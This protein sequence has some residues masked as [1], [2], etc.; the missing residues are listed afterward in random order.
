MKNN[1]KILSLNRKASYL[2]AIKDKFEAGIV[3]TGEEVKSIRKGKMNIDAAFITEQQ[4]ELYLV[5]SNIAKY[6]KSNYTDHE[7]VRHRKLLLHKK[8]INKII[9]SIKMPKYS[10]IVLKIYT[11]LRNKIKL[12]IAIACGKTE[13]DKRATIKEREWQRE[14]GKLLKINKNHIN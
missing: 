3:L 7:E 11:N 6:E 8:Q 10:A 9:G 4:G 14:K 5:N 1:E 13:I 2:Y 12:E